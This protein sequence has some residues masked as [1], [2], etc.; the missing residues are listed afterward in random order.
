MVRLFSILF[1]LLFAS[2]AGGQIITGHL[3][4]D[5]CCE[6]DNFNFEIRYNGSIEYTSVN[7]I[8]KDVI[9][10]LL[11][12]TVHKDSI[13]DARAVFD[14]G[15]IQIF[16]AYKGN[17]PSDRMDLWLVT[18]HHSYASYAINSG[19]IVPAFTNA[20]IDG[21][22]YKCEQIARTYQIRSFMFKPFSSKSIPFS[23]LS[24][25]YRDGNLAD[26]RNVANSYRLVDFFKELN[27]KTI[28]Y[29]DSSGNK[30]GISRPTNGW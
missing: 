17:V 19:I 25:G 6:Q 7:K 12:K 3:V 4:Y 29:M 13:I 21:L 18:P 28:W 5:V 24:F 27:W 23:V 2:L 10:S 9:I 20:N 8:N 30:K 14:S 26:M 16:F 15:K 1:I 22:Q 11:S